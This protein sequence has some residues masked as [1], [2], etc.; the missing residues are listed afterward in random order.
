MLVSHAPGTIKQA[1][2]RVVVLDAGQVVFDGPTAEGLDFYHRMLGI[3]DPEQAAARRARD[4]AVTLRE[5][6]LQDGDG[7]SQQVFETGE[8]LRLALDLEADPG[9]PDVT[10][11]I[12]FRQSLGNPV[13]LSRTPVSTSRG[14]GALVLEIPRLTLLGGDYDVA[15][16]IHE[17]GDTAPGID[18]LLSFSVAANEDAEGIVDL[19]GTWS[20]SGA[21]AELRR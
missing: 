18:R 13:F 12:E 17:P 16:G 9:S 6:S 19:R 5:A 15:I 11:V 20:F 1:C 8:Q 2:R 14:G 3:E 10:V 4:G 21:S 7:R